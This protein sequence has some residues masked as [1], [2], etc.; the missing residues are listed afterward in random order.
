MCQHSFDILILAVAAPAARGWGRPD[1]LAAVRALAAGDSWLGLTTVP[2]WPGYDALARG[3]D[4]VVL[5]GK[6]DFSATGPI[7]AR[8]ITAALNLAPLTHLVVHLASSGCNMDM[9]AHFFDQLNMPSLRTL[10]VADKLEPDAVPSIGGYLATRGA[11]LNAL[12]FSGLKHPANEWDGAP[13]S[14]ATLGPLAARI[15]QHRGLHHFCMCR[16]TVCAPDGRGFWAGGSCHPSDGFKGFVSDEGCDAVEKRLNDNARPGRLARRAVKDTL[17]PARVVMRATN[18]R[19]GAWSLFSR[20]ADQG[21]APRLPPELLV[22]VLELLAPA[23]VLGPSERKRLYVLAG[24][25]AK[26]KARARE[27]VA[28]AKA[29]ARLDDMMEDWI[30]KERLLAGYGGG[31]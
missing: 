8:W 30:L 28:G 23:G 27:V 21:A 3:M 14:E 31:V 22:R 18:A 2:T 13:P 5:S 17:V 16:G 26:L 1:P 12:S 29:G 24:D 15:G 11:A 6:C 20:P 25:R 9:Q 7:V 4:S 19:P 10:I